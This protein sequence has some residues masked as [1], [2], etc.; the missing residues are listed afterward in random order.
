[1]PPHALRP[2]SSSG[3]PGPP[4]PH[5]PPGYPMP[6]RMPPA[7][8]PL[9]PSPVR[10]SA[11]K[12]LPAPAKPLPLEGPPTGLG[13]DLGDKQLLL[14]VAPA[15]VSSMIERRLVGE[16]ALAVT[17]DV[18]DLL[19]CP[20]PLAIPFKKKDGSYWVAEE[21][22]RYYERDPA[23]PHPFAVNLRTLKASVSW[24]V[25]VDMSR[26]FG[27]FGREAAPA[28]ASALLTPPVMDPPT[29]QPEE[30]P[31]PEEKEEEKDEDEK[32]DEKPDEKDEKDEKDEEK[33]DDQ[34]KKDEEKRD[35]GK[36]DK[37]KGDKDEE[38]ADPSDKDGEDE[39]EKEGDKDKSEKE[40]EEEGEDPGEGEPEKEGEDGQKKDQ[41]DGK[42]GDSNEKGEDGEPKEAGGEADTDEEGEED[43]D[44]EGDG[45]DKDDPGEKKGKKAGEEGEGEAGDDE[46]TEGE[47]GEGEEGEEDGS[48]EGEGAGAATAIPATNEALERALSGV[49]SEINDKVSDIES[50]CP[51]VTRSDQTFGGD[52]DALLKKVESLMSKPGMRKLVEMAGRMSRSAWTPKTTMS[53]TAIEDVTGIELGGEIERA[54]ASRVMMLAHPDLEVLT[55]KAIGEKTLEQRAYT[56]K[57][58]LARGPIVLLLDESGSMGERWQSDMSRHEMATAMAIGTLRICRLQRRDVFVIGFAAQVTGGYSIKYSATPTEYIE[59]CAR[60]ASRGHY[61]GTNFTDPIVYGLGILNK[62]E[63]KNADLVV[64]TDGEG[65]LE[66]RVSGEIRKLQ[67]QKGLRMFVLQIGG[68]Q[69]SDLTKLADYCHPIRTTKDLDDFGN[70]V[71]SVDAKPKKKS[72]T[73]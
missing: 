2:G 64:A 69:A 62:P 45:E 4:P 34:D 68:R 1:M 3:V 50:L 32:P 66:P 14:D 35:D 57:D 28:I 20:A 26:R 12:P 27:L 13:W 72:S 65:V 71:S 9:V 15:S 16:V 58:L 10:P 38:P 37:D 21:Y 8:P 59:T 67:K 33:P 60:L 30:E 44:G 54:L 40:G 43:G 31:P 17:G 19:Y 11:V 24:Q 46:E 18:A 23:A 7:P 51:G 55:L 48:K 47:D 29:D 61:G 5:A 42:E 36:D 53:N 49:M 41:E 63:Y 73:W 39:G 52:S 25:L 22:T 6:G 56:G 70:A